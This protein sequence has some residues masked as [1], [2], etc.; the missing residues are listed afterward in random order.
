M[1]PATFLITGAA[2]AL[3]AALSRQAAEAGARLMLLDRNSRG[4][5]ALSD[6]LVAEGR[7]TPGLVPLDLA[8]AG[9]EQFAEL[10][11]LVE[12]ECGGLDHLVHCAAH[13]D[14]LSPLDQVAPADWL[15]GLQVNLNAAW[16]LTVACLPLLRRS[17]GPSVTFL[18][19]DP[20]R[21]GDAFWGP[22]GVSKAGLRSLAAILREELEN[23]PVRVHAIDPG[24]FRSPL[25]SRAYH[26]EPPDAQPGPEVVAAELLK[27]LL[28]ES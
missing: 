3:G 24:P 6:A 13:F 16:A 26:A 2:G 4:L 8:A 7:A 25:R 17:P 5:D 9:P 27:R 14:G 20:A 15:T 1:E 28:G 11:D 10:A 12:R 21:S 23:T 19:D 22:Y 18:L